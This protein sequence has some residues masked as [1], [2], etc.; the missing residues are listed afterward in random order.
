MTNE[1][2][3]GPALDLAL[4]RALGFGAEFCQGTLERRPRA[5]IVRCGLCGRRSAGIPGEPHTTP[6]AYST[7]PAAAWAL[8]EALG[9]RGWVVETQR[10][11]PATWSASLGR[12]GHAQPGFWR[13]L[14]IVG[15]TPAEALARAALRALGEGA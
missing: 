3:A 12:G 13:Y 10:L 6:A 4:A 9:A 11:D 7:D 8:L 2:K 14:R 15:T 5:R 1:P